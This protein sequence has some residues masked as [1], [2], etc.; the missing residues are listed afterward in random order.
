MGVLIF[1]TTQVIVNVRLS[2]T[3]ALVTRATEA[4]SNI[5][6]QRH[7]NEA[8]AFEDLV[9]ADEQDNDVPRYHTDPDTFGEVIFFRIFDR[10]GRLTLAA[11]RAPK[12]AQ[13]NPIPD[14][15]PPM[16]EQER[17][18]VQAV[19]ASGRQATTFD[20][21]A[22]LEE[23]SKVFAHSILPIRYRGDILGVAEVVTDAS[24]P[25]DD[26][27][28]AFRWFGLFVASVLTLVSLIPISVIGYSWFR[29]SRLNVE[30]A[31]AH[32]KAR[33]AEAVK[34]R[35]LANMS[36]EIR[37]P[38]NGI[39]GMAEL[40]SET[41]LSED[42]RGYSDTILNASAAL[43]TIINDILDFSKIEAGRVAI[44]PAP[45]DL[46][47]C[48]QDAATLLFP[49]GDS[50][51]VELCVDFQAPLPAWVVGDEAR[52]RQCLLNVAGNAMKFTDSGHVTI[53]VST[54]DVD[55]IE[56]DVR[57]TGI[58]IPQDQI[59]AIFVDFER[60]EERDRQNRP[61]TGLGL[62]ITRRLLRLMGGDISV[63]STPGEGS[64]FRMLL[65]LPATAPPEM[66]QSDAPVLFPDPAA[67]RGR[68]A[69]VVDDLEVNRR[70][71]TARLAGFGMQSTACDSAL[72]ALAALR[73]GRQPLPDIVVSDHQMPG[74]DGAGLLRELRADPGMADLPVVILSSGEMETLRAAFPNGALEFFLSKPVRTDRLYDTLCRAMGV[75]GAPPR[76]A[77]PPPKNSDTAEPAPDTAWLTV[78]LAEDNQTNRFIVEKMIT[79]RVARV[80][81]WSDGQQAVDA[82]LAERPDVI[83]MD[84]SMPG[85]DGLTATRE[86]R[87]LERRAGRPPCVIVALTAH[88]LTEDRDRSA[89]VGMDGFL[90]KPIRKARLVEALEAA[91]ARLRNRRVH[92]PDRRDTG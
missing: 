19:L 42:Q 78:G 9:L 29:Q 63:Q 55:R 51:G 80:I 77:A 89:E 76:T 60:V 61:G 47:E 40:L 41:R 37:T 91:A 8:G 59:D 11:T 66:T 12:P 38:L 1:A 90:S 64:R 26:I 13:A 35:F 74:M 24:D 87:A 7:F 5:W 6:Y 30:L 4:I 10:H 65:P 46:H 49:V 84:I 52:L 68:T 28:A 17:T 58:G 32:D 48:V 62:A 25:T 72:A 27:T 82:Y 39:M 21:G 71:L 18:A 53:R 81:P 22:P 85:K 16:T 15:P 44:T 69:V 92:T 33:R 86:I 83:L 50:K 34:S 2:V 45:F 75:A 14:G 57:D 3:E 54:P 88:A 79:D 56:I 73:S 31:R 43:L 67:L 70:I 23:T 20:I 36:H